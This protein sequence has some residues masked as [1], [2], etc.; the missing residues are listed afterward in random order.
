MIQKQP[1]GQN[2]NRKHHLEG[3]ILSFIAESSLPLSVVPKLIEFS[4]F[5]SRDPKALYQLRVNQ[6]AASYKLKHGLSVHIRKKVVDCIKKYPFSLNIDECTSN[7]SQKVFSIIVSSLIKRLEKSVVQHY[8]SISLIEVNAKCLLECICNCFIRDDIP[9]Q[10][11]VS[12]LSDGTNYMKGKEEGL[13]N[14]YEA[15]LHNFWTLTATFAIISTVPSSNSVN[16]LNF[17]LKNGLMTFIGTQI[18]VLIFWI[19]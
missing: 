4:Q 13:K 3:Y 19:R 16:L 11:L 12:D 1:Q 15:K 2:L 9:F 14:C 17:L 10:N 7:I 5:L 18:I 8:E 6:T